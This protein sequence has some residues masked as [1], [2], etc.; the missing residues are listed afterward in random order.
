MNDDR[1]L[2]ELIIIF[3]FSVFLINQIF[4]NQIQACCL[5]YLCL[6]TEGR[7]IIIKLYIFKG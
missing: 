4:L 3:I 7:S 1:K 6:H 2:F 5:S